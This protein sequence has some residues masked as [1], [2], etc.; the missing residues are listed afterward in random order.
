MKNV[1]SD[2]ENVQ[3][4]SENYRGPKGTWT[5][6]WNKWILK[7]QDLN[8]LKITDHVTLAKEKKDIDCKK[9]KADA[10]TD[11]LANTSV[12]KFTSVG[13]D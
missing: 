3:Y 4:V 8:Y 9:I 10:N 6:K 1:F 12:I 7:G 11:T 2:C 13:I 5:E